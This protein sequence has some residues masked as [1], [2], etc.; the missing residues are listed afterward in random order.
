[1]NQENEQYDLTGHHYVGGPRSFA[2][3]LGS[4]DYSHGPAYSDASE[5]FP[6]VSGKGFAI[7]STKFVC[8]SFQYVMG[9]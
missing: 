3:A 1:V 7:A 5:Q 6:P 4:A 2:A 8:T 9:Y